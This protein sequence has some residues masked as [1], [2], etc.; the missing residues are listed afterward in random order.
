MGPFSYWLAM[1]WLIG[2]A[3]LNT[4]WTLW[5]VQFLPPRVAAHFGVG[6]E[7]NGW[8][9]RKGFA[10]F[11]ILFPIALSAFIVSIGKSTQSP[12]S[13]PMDMERFATGLVLFFSFLSWSIVRSNKRNPPRVDYPSLLVS[14][15]AL[16]IFVSIWVG[17]L[18]KAPSK[19][20]H[21][22]SIPR[23]LQK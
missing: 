21:P 15:G 4:V 17:G 1:V 20:N 9:S 19:P 13:S 11:S 2:V 12:E 14:I 8:M 23:S 7:A 22:S 5:C 10:W 3:I 16:L 18:S 6:G